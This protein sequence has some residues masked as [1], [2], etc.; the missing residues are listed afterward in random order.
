MPS[1]LPSAPQ[2]P[3]AASTCWG[4]KG[5]PAGR[6][7]YRHC[8]PANMSGNALRPKRDAVWSL[9]LFLVH[10]CAGTFV[11]Q[12]CGAE[13]MRHKNQAARHRSGYY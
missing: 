5:A 2:R 9:A 12:S 8:S 4:L 1:E 6:R 10:R 3:C 11:A 7:R 13:A